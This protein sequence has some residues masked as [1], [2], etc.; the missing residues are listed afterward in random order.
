[1][2]VHLKKCYHQEITNMIIRDKYYIE[3]KDVY[4]IKLIKNKYNSYIQVIYLIDGIKVDWICYKKHI[5]IKKKRCY[6][7]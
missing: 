1:M 5:L 7:I 4:S 6:S 3:T 2:G